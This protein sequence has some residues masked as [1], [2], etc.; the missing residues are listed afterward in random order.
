M[1]VETPEVC[2]ASEFECATKFV[3]GIAEIKAPVYRLPKQNVDAPTLNA[4]TRLRQGY[5][6]VGA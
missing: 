6:A 1:G 5:G 3:G 4:Q 2:A